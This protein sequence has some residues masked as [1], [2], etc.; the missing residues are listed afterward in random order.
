MRSFWLILLA[1]G[2]MA[3]V[4]A[5]QSQSGGTN[6]ASGVGAA[7]EWPIVPP[8]SGRHRL[9]AADANRRAECRQPDTGVDLQPAAAPLPPPPGEAVP[10]R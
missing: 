1:G 10:A 4:L 3:A 2:T 9:L 8:R 7:T 6:P 5:A